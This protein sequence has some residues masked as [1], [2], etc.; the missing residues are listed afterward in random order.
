MESHPKSSARADDELVALA[1]VCGEFPGTSLEFVPGDWEDG[2]RIMVAMS[3]AAKRPINWNVL[4]PLVGNL[5]ESRGRLDA[6]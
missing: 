5:E 2:A 6:S 1:A 3:V 4:I